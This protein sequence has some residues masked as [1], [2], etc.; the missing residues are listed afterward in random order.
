[1]ISYLAALTLAATTANAASSLFFPFYIYPDAVYGDHCAN[2]LPVFDSIA[3]QPNLHYIFVINPGS[4]P[5]EVN[6]QPDD[7]WQECIPRLYASGLNVEVC[8]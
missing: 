2:W 6:S 7:T 4:G 5:G 3:A 8:I 1:M